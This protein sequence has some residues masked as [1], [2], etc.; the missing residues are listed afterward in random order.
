[1]VAK[2]EGSRLEVVVLGQSRLYDPS[3][4]DP[5]PGRV[6]RWVALFARKGI[7][8]PTHRSLWMRISPLSH[9]TEEQGA[10][11]LAH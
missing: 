7:F 10:T 2:G 4:L 1:M 6:R 8:N 9:K 5:A 3:D 11:S